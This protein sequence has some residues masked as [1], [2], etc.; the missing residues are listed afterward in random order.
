MKD[1]LGKIKNENKICY[2]VGVYNINLIKIES[3]SLTSEFNDAMYS[4]GFIP[5]ITRPT[6][7]TQTSASLIHSNQILDRRH[8]LN[9][10]MMTDV[11]DPY[12]IFHVAK[13]SHPQNIEISITR[14]NYTRNKDNFRSQLSNINWANVFQSDSTQRAFS[15]FHNELRKLHDRCFPL[16]HISK[17]YNTRKPWLADALRVSIKKKN[18][19]YRKSIKIKSVHNEMVYKN[20]RKTLKHLFKA[21]EKKCYSELILLNKSNSKKMWSILKKIINRN[22]EKYI[23]RRFK[24]SDGSEEFHICGLRVIYLID[25]SL[26]HK[27]VFHHQL[28]LYNVVCHFGTSFVSHLYKWFGE[29]MFPLFANV[30]CRRY[31]SFCQWK[32]S[33]FY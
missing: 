8:S 18:K 15:L 23:N 26:L 20:Y 31:K 30:I 12:P 16:Q 4:G 5:L 21:A 9:G 13:Y 33:A 22:K 27:M 17:K 11:S 19:L 29:C 3:H 28:R 7:V 25:N 32:W 6:R 14:R 2:L 24:L 10:I 1:T